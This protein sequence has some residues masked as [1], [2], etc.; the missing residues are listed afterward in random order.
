LIKVS[1][2]AWWLLWNC[3]AVKYNLVRHDILQSNINVC[4]SG[5]G[6]ESFDHLFLGCSNFGGSWDIVLQWLGLQ[7]VKPSVLVDHAISFS[8]LLWLFKKKENVYTYDM[9]RYVLVRL[10]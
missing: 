8:A 5:C 1:I 2:F 9:A 6:E 7:L 10:G 4:V 3:L